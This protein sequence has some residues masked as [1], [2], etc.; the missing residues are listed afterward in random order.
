MS[1]LAAMPLRV[2]ALIAARSGSKGLRHKNVRPLAGRPLLARAVDLARRSARRGEQW[3]I[4][5]STD[6][7]RYAR[8]AEAAGAE[9]PFVRPAGLARDDTRLTAVVHHA[10]EVLAEAGRRFDA[11]VL[12][13]PA[14]PL[15]RPVD[16]RGA[17]A[18]FR[19][20]RGAAVISV[21][22]ER[23]IPSWR[24]TLRRGRLEAPAGRRVGRRQ[25]ATP[26]YVLNGAIYVATPTWLARHGQFWAPGARAFVMPASRSLDIE[27]ARDLAIARM[28]VERS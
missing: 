18:L 25:E 12:L 4:V 16:V 10:L 28:L 15:T 22:A 24:F 8:I 19:A 3:S 27:S 5:V 14:T 6:S 23:T 26:T 21:T 1:C 7:R 9:V 13:S 20:G 17:L 2:L 11:V